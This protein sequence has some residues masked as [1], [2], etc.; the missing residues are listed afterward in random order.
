MPESSSAHWDRSFSPTESGDYTTRGWFQSSADPS[1]TMIGD[2]D[3]STPAIDVGA[4]ASVWIDEALDRGWSELSVIDWS[5]VALNISRVRLS[6]RAD[7]VNWINHDLLS[8]IPPRTYGL[9]HDR[10]VL[11]FLLDDQQ[12]ARYA[13][14]LRAATAPGSVVVIGGF[15]ESGPDMCAGLPVRHQSVED[16]E[17]LFGDDFTIEQSFDQV[18]IRPDADTQDYVWVRAVRL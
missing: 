2:L 18:H 3:V 11:H 17:T 8:W 6:S 7:Q 12:R 14:V 13:S 1:W 16:F 4:G 9:W 10:A 5:V 15:S